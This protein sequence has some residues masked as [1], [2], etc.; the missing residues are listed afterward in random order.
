[1]S[2]AAG[3]GTNAANALKQWEV[4]NN[5]ETTT[6]KYYE[7]NSQKEK[8]LYK[9]KPWKKNPKYFTSVKMS[10]LAL[11]KI[12][13]H[14]KTG[15]GKLGTIT[16]DKDNW[17]EVM[18]LTQGYYSDNTI[19]I[20]DSFG[21]PV[22]ANEVEAVMN[23]E[24]TLYMINYLQASGDLGKKEGCVGWYHSHPGYTCFLSGTDVNTQMLNQSVQDPWVAIVVDPVRTIST[25]KVAVKAFRTFPE[26]YEGGDADFD[27]DQLPP[28]KIEEFGVHMKRYYE[29]PITVYRSTADAE[30]LNR[31]WNRYWQQTLATS[32]LLTN[33]F[34]TTTLI[35]QVVT[36]LDNASETAVHGGDFSLRRQ[37]KVSD[38]GISAVSRSVGGVS[39]DTLQGLMSMLV[40]REVF[41]GGRGSVPPTAA[42]AVGGGGGASSK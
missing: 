36:K 38:G 20:T 1:M 18:G 30:Q 27:R 29:V 15:Q 24:S 4:Q 11:I 25:G 14:A 33:R 28:E 17:V 35:N 10:S 37:K 31:L 23:E 12:V 2:T 40:K 26:N 39:S 7:Y 41:N 3:L 13:M 42:A 9:E 19:V 22:D 8:D 34:Y 6:N 21:L 16:T 32:P 5:V